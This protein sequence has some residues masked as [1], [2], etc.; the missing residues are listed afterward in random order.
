MIH[1]EPT[2]PI[3]KT[4]Q[5]ISVMHDK[6]ILVLGKILYQGSSISQAEMEVHAITTYVNL[7]LKHKGFM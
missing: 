4:K 7:N 3:P 1:E 2:C 6:Y 5:P